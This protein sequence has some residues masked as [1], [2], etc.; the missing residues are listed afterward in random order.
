MHGKQTERT[1]VNP[2]ANKL[3]IHFRQSLH[4][5]NVVHA[6]RPV[7]LFTDKAW[8]LR[9]VSTMSRAWCELHI[10]AWLFGM[11]TRYGQEPGVNQFLSIEGLSKEA[12]HGGSSLHQKITTYTRSWKT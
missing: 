10:V 12:L 5:S 3:G 9:K 2:G 7:S 8:K 6:D 11:M 4:A 1:A